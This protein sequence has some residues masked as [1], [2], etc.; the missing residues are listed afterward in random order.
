M[1]IIL[2]FDLDQ[3][4]TDSSLPGLFT[5]PTNSEE[6]DKLRALIKS[7]LNMNVVN[8]LKRA[9]P[10]RLTGGVTAICLL[11][12]NASSTYVSMVDSVLQELCG[13]TGKYKT[14]R[15]NVNANAMP[16]KPYFFDSIFMRGHSTRAKNGNPSKSLLDVSNMMTFLKEYGSI[17]SIIKDTY[18]F[19]DIGTHLMRQEFNFMESGKYKDHYIQ[20]TPPYSIGFQDMTD[21]RPVLRALSALD[22]KPASL[23]LLP[24]PILRPPIY[25]TRPPSGIAMSLAKPAS[26]ASAGPT[27]LS[28]HPYPIKTQRWPSALSTPVVNEKPP[29]ESTVHRKPNSRPSLMGIFKKPGGSRKTRRKNT[30]RKSTAKYES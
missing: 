6:A 17:H 19:D 15:E 21:Y 3:T 2:V 29:Q 4:I 18:F 10:L 25:M 9:T 24:P 27:H 13:S 26:A 11:T 28:P 22:G 30:T 16:I 5:V 20:I 7:A 14:Y 1:G 8:L 23:P 12:N